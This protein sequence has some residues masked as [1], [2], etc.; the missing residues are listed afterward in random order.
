MFLPSGPFELHATAT[1]PPADDPDVV[2]EDQPCL[3][4]NEIGLMWEIEVQSDPKRRG[5]A[6]GGIF[7]PLVPDATIDIDAFAQMCLNAARFFGT[8][9][10]HLVAV[11]DAE[12]GI[13]NVA[14]EQGDGVGPFL[15]AAVDWNAMIADGT[16]GFNARGRFNPLAQPFVAAKAAV[17]D[18][19]VLQ[20]CLPNRL[21]TSAELSDHLI[22]ADHAIKVLSDQAASFQTT[23]STA[24]GATDFAI[25]SGNRPWLFGGPIDVRAAMEKIARR[26]D[27]GYDRADS[28]FAR[29]EPDFGSVAAAGF[30]GRLCTAAAVEWD[31][32]GDN[33][34][35]LAGQTIKAGHREA[36]PGF[37]ERIGEYWRPLGDMSSDGRT[38]KP[39]SAAF[40]SF[41]VKGAGVGNKFR[42]GANTPSTSARRY[43]T[44]TT[45]RTSLIG[46]SD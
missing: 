23:V 6:R 1:S 18:A 5:F 16:T 28:L 25:L 34:L 43:A 30:A 22:G 9:A 37:F 4:L 8:S 42:G 17:A 35:N 46:A 45:K 10:Q 26:L 40:I 13:R 24:I 29:I 38:N 11:A 33:T 39:W 20:P 15:I 21:P 7:K 2:E 32:F 14:A 44:S 27:F 12:T 36:E 19:K 31:F 41:C 3:K